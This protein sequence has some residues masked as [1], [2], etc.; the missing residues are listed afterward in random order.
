MTTRMKSPPDMDAVRSITTR[1]NASAT[2]AEVLMTQIDDGN[3]SA[4]MQRRFSDTMLA[5]K[6]GIEDARQLDDAFTAIQQR[7]KWEVSR[8]EMAMKRAKDRQ[9][10]LKQRIKDVVSSNP[11]VIFK[12]AN[13]G[14]ISVRASNPA[15]KFT[16]ELANKNISNIVPDNFPPE[17]TEPVSFRVVNT[18]AVREALDRGEKLDFAWLEQGQSLHGL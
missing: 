18:R 16:F 5:T 10:A 8:L 14:K 6:K 2:L 9:H 15:L 4:E 11:S 12:D 13:G 7:L 3:I 1:L 17:Y